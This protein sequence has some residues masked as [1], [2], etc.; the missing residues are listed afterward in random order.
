MDNID[1]FI[2]KILFYIC[3]ILSRYGEKAY[4][5]EIEKIVAEFEDVVKDE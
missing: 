2:I 5:F 4:N 1:K 3:K